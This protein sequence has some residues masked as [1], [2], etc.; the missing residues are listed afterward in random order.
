MGSGTNVQVGAFQPESNRSPQT[1]SALSNQWMLAA[2]A[3]VA[4]LWVFVASN[5]WVFVVS[6]AFILGI[7][8]LGLLVIVGW[9]REVSLAQAGLVGTAAYIC[10][11]A[12]RPGGLGLPFP[13]AA[14]LAI[15]VVIA[16]SVLVALVAVK[17][18]GV[19]VMVL[20]LA[21]QFL[22][23]NTVYTDTRMTGGLTAVETPRPALFGLNLESDKG[24]YFFCLAALVAVVLFLRRFRFSRF[25]R[26]LLLVGWD[27][28]AAAAVGVSPWGYKVLAFALGGALA[29]VAGVLSAPYFRA[30]PGPLQ[31]NSFV[32]LFYLAIPVLAGF[33]SLLGVVGVAIA[34]T[35]IPVALESAHISP[36][37]LGGLGLAFGTLIGPLGVSGAVIDAVGRLRRRPREI[38]LTEAEPAAAAIQFVGDGVAVVSRSGE[39]G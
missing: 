15:A 32:T 30:P 39:G 11:Y 34:F 29:G 20:T 35:V 7:T 1:R 18:S 31:F 25:G 8:T 33:G 17:L 13:V 24:F 5:Y 23:E 14:A 38:R 19:Y 22:L 10:G 12:Y 26:S 6:G 37:L 16:L 28:Q 2:L 4:C 36:Y 9:G 21:L 3:A 27:R